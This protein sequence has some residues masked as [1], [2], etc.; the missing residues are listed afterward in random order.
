MQ[1]FARYSLFAFAGVAAIAAAAAIDSTLHPVLNAVLLDLGLVSVAVVLID[2][3]WRLAGGNP[4]EEQIASLG[5]EINRLGQTVDV[6][7]NTRSV[8]LESVFDCTGNFGGQA[9]WLGLIEQAGQRMDLMGR[10]LENW[11]RP[12]EISSL[13]VRKIV[14]EDVK[15][16]WLVMSENNRYLRLLEEGGMLLT[17]R[18]SHKLPSVYER[19]RAVRDLLPED[20]RSNLQVRLFSNEPLY[21]SVIRI[22]NRFLV[23]PYLA[24]VGA[25]DCPLICF[26]GEHSPWARSFGGEFEHVWKGAQ[27]L[28][29]SRVAGNETPPNQ[30]AAGGPPASALPPAGGR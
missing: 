26:S 29:S 16:R 7:Q 18:V 20:K 30:P 21:C 10:A 8:G 24:V 4:V 1:A 13:L 22:D 9:D 5:S 11:V 6:I 28:F 27:D 17:E 12:N 14:S 3:L 2:A 15:F 23:T 19:L 25:R